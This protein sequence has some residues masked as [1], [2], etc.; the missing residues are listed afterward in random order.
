MAQ[1]KA[2]GAAVVTPAET[3][4]APTMET[5][6]NVLSQ[7]TNQVA[8]LSNQVTQAIE[9][10]GNLL[11]RVGNLEEKYKVCN[12][13]STVD[14]KLRHAT[15]VKKKTT[16]VALR[17]RPRKR[18][19]AEKKGNHLTCRRRLRASR[20]RPRRY[21]NNIAAVYETRSGSFSYT[22]TT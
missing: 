10:I 8:H 3:T 17:G 1:E 14:A 5:A 22:W 6:M 21:S 9:Q 4:A 18:S 11:T 20:K 7:L 16:R 2:E 15:L 12:R 19:T 13:V